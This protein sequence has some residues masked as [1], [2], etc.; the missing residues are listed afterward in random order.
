MQ[1][2]NV[3]KKVDIKVKL[4]N[5][6]LGQ[7]EVAEGGKVRNVLGGWIICNHSRLTK[8]GYKGTSLHVTHIHPFKQP[9]DLSD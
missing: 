9:V 5:Y 1:Y 6:A 2:E 4:T 7:S 3:S 8:R